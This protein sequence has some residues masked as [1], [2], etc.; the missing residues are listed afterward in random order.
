MHTCMQAASIYGQAGAKCA[1]RG[2]VRE[3]EFDS[4]LN[5]M[6]SAPL[7]CDVHA[8]LMLKWPIH[9]TIVFQS[10]QGKAENTLCS[11]VC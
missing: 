10:C 8:H 1:E 2:C 11:A 3:P 5:L 9:G 7:P 6:D 4:S